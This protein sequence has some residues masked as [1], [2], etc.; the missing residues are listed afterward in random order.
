MGRI[1]SGIKFERI[2]P[3]YHKTVVLGLQEFFLE[4]IRLW[5]GNGSCVEELWKSYKHIIFKGIKR[6]VTKKILS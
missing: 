5:A 3:A 1:L 2:V 4:K 6:Y